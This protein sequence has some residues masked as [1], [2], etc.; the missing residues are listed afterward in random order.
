LVTLDAP[1]R[2]GASGALVVPASGTISIRRP[3]G[4]LAVS[5]AACTVASSRLTYDW[6]PASTE[7]LGAGWSIE[8][9]PTIGTTAYPTMRASAYLVEWAPVNVVSELDLYARIPELRYRVPQAQGPTAQGGDG[10]GWQPQIDE[11]FYGLIQRMLDD[12]RD[13]TKVR[14]PTGYREWLICR[15]IQLAVG[16]VSYGPDSTWADKAKD[17]AFAMRTAE[18]GMRLQFSDIAPDIRSGGRP[19]VRLCSVSRPLC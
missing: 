4:D 16:A 1:I 15:A 10:S 12:G 5:A 17:A 13:I 3:G 14:E 6:T 7:V 9:T 11:A 2:Y 8:W 19:L 18:A